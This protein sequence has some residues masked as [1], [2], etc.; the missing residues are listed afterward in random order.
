MK[1]DGTEVHICPPGGSLIDTDSDNRD[2][3][4]VEHT[5]RKNVD[6][7]RII[8]FSVRLSSQATGRKQ[9]P[10]FSL[11]PVGCK[12]SFINASD[13]TRY[14]AVPLSIRGPTSL[15]SSNYK[16]RRY[17]SSE[18]ASKLCIFHKHSDTCT[19][20]LLYSVNCQYLSRAKVCY[21]SQ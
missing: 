15:D 19:G 8:S 12:F 6:F 18:L 9:L 14:I 2:Q 3:T 21:Y 11:I 20:Q 5:D 17:W 13:W 7:L 4:W 1:R 16:V 10:L